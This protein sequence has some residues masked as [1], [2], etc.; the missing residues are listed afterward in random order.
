MKSLLLSLSM[1]SQ[2][3]AWVTH[4][5]P[6]FLRR[7]FD[8]NSSFYLTAHLQVHTRTFFSLQRHWHRDS[9]KV[10]QRC[11]KGVR[12]TRTAPKLSAIR[13]LFAPICSCVRT[14]S[15]GSRERRSLAVWNAHSHQPQSHYIQR[16]VSRSSLSLEIGNLCPCRQSTWSAPSVWAAT[17]LRRSRQCNPKKQNGRLSTSCSQGASQTASDRS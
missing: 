5:P 3:Q 6:S 17:E 13:P 11:R 4:L 16:S 10:I 12:A 8:Y 2:F 7:V 15:S 9:R 14:R 1:R